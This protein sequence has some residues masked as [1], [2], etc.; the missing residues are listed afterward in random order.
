MPKAPKKTKRSSTWF[1]E[2]SAE[3]QREYVKAHPRSKYAKMLRLEKK[4]LPAYR[5]GDKQKLEA[6]YRKHDDITG[7]K[8]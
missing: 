4:M 1:A 7:R 8:R 6:L 3:K 2:L 5:S